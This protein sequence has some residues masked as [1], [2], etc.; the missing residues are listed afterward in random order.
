[1]LNSL[2]PSAP[3]LQQP[4]MWT[5]GLI[6]MFFPQHAPT[7]DP[8]ASVCVIGNTPLHRQL[9]V[10]YYDSVLSI[11]WQ[12]NQSCKWGKSAGFQIVHGRCFI[13][14]FLN[15]FP[16]VHLLRFHGFA[17]FLQ[18]F[19]H[20]GYLIPFDSF[21]FHPLNPVSYQMTRLSTPL[22]VTKYFRLGTIFCSGCHPMFGATNIFSDK[23]CC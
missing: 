17:R 13:F 18:G 8:S 21:Y 4:D 9:F 1:M 5:R 16:T 7:V 14:I 19:V 3:N 15:L 20:T 11:I 23:A 22:C 6:P 2:P 12:T 10:Q